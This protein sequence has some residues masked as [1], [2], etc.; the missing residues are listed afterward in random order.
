LR[1][2]V[3]QLLGMRI[4]AHAAVD[5]SV[6]LVA[7]SGKRPATGFANGVL[8]AVARTPAAEW[9]ARLLDGLDG[10]DRLAATTAHPPW[11]V[12]AFRA[13][14][15]AER[16][17]DELPALLEADNAPPRVALVA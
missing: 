4:P 1:L 8:R 5:E 11:I 6:S 13:V 9:E 16:A 17:E 10:D 7:R 12:E 14:L 3:R 15:A 2:G